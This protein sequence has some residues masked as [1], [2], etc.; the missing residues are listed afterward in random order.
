MD[1]SSDV[2]ALVSG[3]HVTLYYIA[4]TV[5][6]LK[7]LVRADVIQTE[8]RITRTGIFKEKKEGT[9]IVT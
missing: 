1:V 5:Q 2:T 7:I 9:D 8:A 6:I 3:H 4:V